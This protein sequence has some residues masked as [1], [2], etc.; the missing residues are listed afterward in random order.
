MNGSS[1]KVIAERVLAPLGLDFDRVWTTDALP[2]FHVHR[3][4]RTQGDAMSTSYD[5]FAAKR[6]LPL[7]DLPTRPSVDQLIRRSIKEEGPRLQAELRKSQAPLLITLGNEAL[8]VAAALLDGDLPS[9]L[10]PDDSYGTRHQARLRSAVLE[11]LPLVHPGQRSAAWLE[12]HDRWLHSQAYI[13]GPPAT[14]ER[15]HA[16]QER[17]LTEVGST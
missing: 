13:L 2:F 14:P 8:A 6:G 4:P 11:V 7:H 1:G 15:L 3:G 17:D 5:P 10:Q 9:R 16:D 12:A